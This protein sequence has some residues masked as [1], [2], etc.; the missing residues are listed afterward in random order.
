MAV[1]LVDLT[2]L[3]V[4]GQ[5]RGRRDDPMPPHSP[6]GR[7][8]TSADSIALSG[9]DKRGRPTYR[10]SSTATSW[11]SIN[12]SATTSDSPCATWG[13]QP[14]IPRATGQRR[15]PTSPI[16][17]SAEMTYDPVSLDGIVLA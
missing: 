13:N 11:R 6:R 9:H 12:S 14:N 1:R 5:Q 16:L 7:A 8:G 4:P 3:P 2:F 15:D 10:R 17:G